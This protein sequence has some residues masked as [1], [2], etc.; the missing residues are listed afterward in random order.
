MPENWPSLDGISGIYIR[1][2]SCWNWFLDSKILGNLPLPIDRLSDKN[3]TGP[4]HVR[5]TLMIRGMNKI[6]VVFNIDT[7]SA[8][9]FEFKL[10][11][12]FRSC[13][14]ILKTHSCRK[15]DINLLFWFYGSAIS[16]LRNTSITVV[17]IYGH[18][19]EQHISN[20]NTPVHFFHR[21]C[22]TLKTRQI[23]RIWR[24]G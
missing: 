6:V 19:H 1:A 12:F 15:I 14:R 3:Y 22:T 23:P 10:A 24:E 18:R 7:M 13:R 2:A 11:F 8:M 9:S 17:N 16:I 21:S 5:R 4:T 20:Q